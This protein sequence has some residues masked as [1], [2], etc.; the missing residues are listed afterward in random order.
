MIINK[1]SQNWSSLTQQ[2]HKLST[3]YNLAI[4]SSCDA[5]IQEKVILCIY[6][7]LIKIAYALIQT[8]SYLRTHFY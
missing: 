7:L 6:N 2:T 5:F 4:L 3:L 8:A 1:F